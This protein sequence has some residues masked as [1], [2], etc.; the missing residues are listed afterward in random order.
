MKLLLASDLHY[1]PNL[2]EEIAVNRRRL[3]AGT[4][5]HQDEGKLYWHN[6]MMVEA[7][8]QLLDGL[9]ALARQERPDLLIFLG[10]MVNVNWEKS[11]AAVGARFARFP[12]PVR[13]V[14]GNH[15]LYLDGAQNRLQDAVTP[16]TYATGIRHETV[17]GLGLIYLD[18]FVQSGD[19]DYRKWSDP[20]AGEPILYRPEDMEA[21]LALMAAE[22][23]KPWLIFGHF[24]FVSPDNRIVLAGRK[25]GLRWPNSV[26]LA[27]HLEQS[28][29][30]LGMICGH[31]HFAH[32]Q[33]FRHGFHW[34]LPALVEYPCAAALI[35]WNGERLSG[36]VIQIDRALAET[37]L[38]LN[39]ES[40]TAGEAEDRSLVWP[41]NP[42]GRG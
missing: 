15:D 35:E 4:Y 18:L 1:V 40:W 31:Q 38:S 25:I 30:L 7:G 33:L 6:Q 22:P 13:Q 27:A 37:S 12:C 2:T 8:E 14:T 19:G 9:E 29:N 36:R 28:N 11:V 34:T 26:L 17:D 24:P 23:Q 41:L 32:L 42:A 10:D 3:P 20:Q 16:G 21:A 5:N 39:Q